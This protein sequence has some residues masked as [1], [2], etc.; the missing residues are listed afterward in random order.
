MF[1]AREQE[2]AIQRNVWMEPRRK[3]AD[4]EMAGIWREWFMGADSGDVEESSELK[5]MEMRVFL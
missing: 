4:A 1:G 2:W 3:K 5:R